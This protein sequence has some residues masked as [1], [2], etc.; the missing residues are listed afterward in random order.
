M[1]CLFALLALLLP[2]LAAAQDAAPQSGE[3]VQDG[4]RIAWT[5]APRGDPGIG[6][7]EVALTDAATGAPL[8]YERGRLAAWLQRRR[9][10]LPDAEIACPDRVRMLAGQ[11]IGQRADIDLN[12]WRLVT[13]NA[14]GTIAVI[15]PF[16]PLNN[17]KLEAIVELGGTPRAWLP[18]PERLEAWV[19]LADP[20]RLVAVDLQSARIA[21]AIDLPEDG[22]QPRLAWDGATGRLFVALEG[23]EGLGEF[24]PDQGAEGLRLI[25]GR[26]PV[27][28]LASEALPGPTTGHADG[29][30][31]LHAAVPRRWMVVAD[32]PVRLLRHSVQAGRIV[33]A[34][35]GGRLGWIDPG[36]ADGTAAERVLELNH[37]VRALELT[38]GGRRALALGGGW[39]S[40]VDL[41]TG[42][43]E[44]RFA[45]L[46]GADALLVTDRF[47]YGLSLA[48]GRATLW[49]LAE[50]RQGAVNPVEVTL[51]RPDA[52]P[53]AAARAVPLPGGS[54]ILVAAPADGMVFQY[55]EGM[56]APIGSFSTYRRAAV[57]LLALDL[58]PREVAA[59]RYAAPVRHLRGG[60][61]DLV[62]AGASPRF[63][64]CMPL[65]LPATAAAP[66]LPDTALR[67]ELAGLTR[68]AAGPAT[69]RVRLSEIG[70][71][72]PRLIDGVADLELLVFDRRTAWE[73]RAPMRAAGAAGEYA[74]RITLPAG[75]RA[76]AMVASISRNLSFAE[77]RVGPLPEAGVP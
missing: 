35:A 27:A 11:G 57:G 60:A 74:A 10:A 41:A 13:L 42:R 21:R 67:V 48:E 59:G 7:L 30:V 71:E 53:G 75:A 39:A 17:A 19:V 1:R 51:G 4:V 12:T 76:E 16:V 22:G 29:S 38:D 62:L 64:L 56:M 18:I 47:A 77:G 34:T 69:L 50:L 66:I 63:A 32:D 33:A 73:A 9:A 58:S 31:T 49:P 20:A 36:A 40:L 43:V 6:T 8:R 54:G 61:H 55:G 15:N 72:T 25:P 24:R 68:E 28:L 70:G 52:T 14:D 65:R 26:A 44:A 5:Y 3:A 45:T 46:P 37:P 23:R 2:G